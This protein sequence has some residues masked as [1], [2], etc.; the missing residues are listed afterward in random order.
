M[1]VKVRV[2]QLGKRGKIFNVSEGQFVKM[3]RKVKMGNVKGDG[4]ES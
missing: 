4:V 1:F 3:K 2:R